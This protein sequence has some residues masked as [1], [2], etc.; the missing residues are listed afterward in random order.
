V[1]IVVY[2]LLI[3]VRLLLSFRLSSR[4]CSRSAFFAAS[5]ALVSSETPVSPEVSESLTFAAPGPHFRSEYIGPSGPSHL[6]ISAVAIGV[7][8][9]KVSAIKLILYLFM[10]CTFRLLMPGEVPIQ[11]SPGKPGKNSELNL[12]SATATGVF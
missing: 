1:L 8:A 6:N 11:Q 10:I 12:A 2:W 3:T 7:I 5:S 9:T 4:A